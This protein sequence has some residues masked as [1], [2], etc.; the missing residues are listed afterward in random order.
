MMAA[1]PPNHSFCAQAT[2][3]RA[4]ETFN[5]LSHLFVLQADLR[6]LATGNLDPRL[7]RIAPGLEASVALAGL[8][9][10][11]MTHIWIRSGL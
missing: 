10:G 11:A 6:H 7:K 3:H 5:N 4:S 8:R 1:P 9:L 2:D